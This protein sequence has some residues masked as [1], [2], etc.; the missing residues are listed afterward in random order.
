MYYIKRKTILATFKIDSEIY[1]SLCI[2]Q[3]NMKKKNVYNDVLML[4]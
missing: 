2:S 4:K 3:R 1:D